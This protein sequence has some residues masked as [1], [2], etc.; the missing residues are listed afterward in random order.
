[1][2]TQPLMY[3]LISQHPGTRK[4]YAD[5][6]AAQGVLRPEDADEMVKAYRSA[7]DEGYHTNKNILTNYHPAYAVNWERF[8]GAKWTD[9]A[10]TGMPLADLKLLGEK[11]TTVPVGIQAA[12]ARRE[13]DRRPPPDDAQGKLPLDWGMAENLAYAA[14][15]K[16]GYARAPVG[17][18][19]RPRH[20]LPP[21]CGAARPGARALG[22]RAPIS[23]CSTSPRT[24]PTSW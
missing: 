4:L 14:L 2:V 3:K 9:P 15:I 6:L 8:R 11:L 21:A 22:C 12:P 10:H 19:H 23:R 7:L 5:R 18:G 16:D 1:M 24:S 13:G 17:S 20:V